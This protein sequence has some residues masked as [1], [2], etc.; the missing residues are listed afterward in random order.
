MGI[1]NENILFDTLNF[2]PCMW[3]WNWLLR[4]KF[5]KLWLKMVCYSTHCLCNDFCYLIMPTRDLLS[6]WIFRS[7]GFHYM[8]P[9]LTFWGLSYKEI[10]T[11][12]RH[13]YMRLIF[14][15]SVSTNGYSEGDFDTQSK[16][17]SRNTFEWKHIWV[18][19]NF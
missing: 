12:Q 17:Y 9:L 19:S 13:V 10:K 4:T 15:L 6:H 1:L 5:D 14:E 11:Q 18:S 7:L 8:L 16:E 3:V 2:K